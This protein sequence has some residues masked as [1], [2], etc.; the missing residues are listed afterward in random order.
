MNV[1]ASQ[2]VQPEANPAETIGAFAAGFSLDQVPEPV[3]RLAKRSL[4]DAIGIGLASADSDYGRR[5]A[6]ALSEVGGPG[7][8]PVLGM[9]LTL[10]QRDAAHLNGTLIHGLDFD[11]THSEAV[12]HASASAAPTMLSAG[13]ATGASGSR[14]LAAFILAS[15]IACR[16]GVAGSGGFHRKGFHPTAVCGAVGSAVGAGYLYGLDERAMVDAQGIVLSQ[17]AGSLQFLD[18]GAW[19]KRNHPGWASVCGQTAAAM[20]KHGFFGPRRAYDGRFGLYALYASPETVIDM[21]RLAGNLGTQWEI[22]GIAF[23]PYPACHMTHAYADAMMALAAEDA[24]KPAQV[25]EIVLHIHPGEIPVIGE[26]QAQKQRPQNSYDAQ[27][28][29][30][31]VAA[32]ALAKGRFTLAELEDAALGDTTVLD[33]CAKTRC[34]PDATLPYPK[35]FPGRVSV[36][37][38]DGRTLERTEPI[39]RG[40][41]DLPLS[42]AEIEAK[43]LDNAQRSLNR[44]QAELIRGMLADL[45]NQKD[46]SVLAKALTKP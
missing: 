28:S 29:C 35:Y 16:A 8:F 20:A 18:D 19:T 30:A 13:L 15:E 22:P 41:A 26:P 12:V 31:Y 24:L 45:E 21:T 11:D 3:V 37:T 14:A 7:R 2:S 44:D 43:F 17:A 33:L 39:N 32:T 46:L 27:F 9:D 25:A 23:K 36:R 1:I 10:S 40:A 34:E 5:T 38:T 4:L 42:D 6:N